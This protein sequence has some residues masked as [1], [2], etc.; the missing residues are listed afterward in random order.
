[1]TVSQPEYPTPSSIQRRL[2]LTTGLV[3]I[4]FLGLVGLVLDQA[5]RSSTIRGAEEQLKLLT[6]SLMGAAE[7]EGGTLVF[8]KDLF[9]P[10]LNQPASGLYAVVMDD[11]GTLL[12]QSPS[13]Q[14]MPP[15]SALALV[16]QLTSAN[17]LAA[18]EAAGVFYFA[19]IDEPQPLFGLS[20]T[21]TWEGLE[22]DVVTFHSLTAQAPFL[23]TINAFRQNVWVGFGLLTIVISIS[24]AAAL[25]WGLRPLRLMQQEVR[26]LEAGRRGRLTQEQPKE[27]VGLVDSLQRY[28][29]HEHRL[30]QRH[31]Q[32]LDNLA[33]SLKTPLAILRNALS[34][35][36]DA[37]AAKGPALR[38]QVDLMDGIITHQLRRLSTGTASAPIGQRTQIAPL[39]TRL[40]NAL[41][42][43][44]PDRVFET[45][46]DDQAG[47]R[48]HADDLYEIFGNIL[49]NACK[50]G[51]QKV[52]IQLSRSGDAESERRVVV[53]LEDDGPGIP[54]EAV[55]LVA[56][57]GQRLDT[58]LPG[59]GI[60]LAVAIELL[61]GS[62]GELGVGR[63]VL[64]GARLI[65]TLPD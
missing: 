11:L 34:A 19:Q 48:M 6:Y 21:V 53:C 35:S 59:Q 28:I 23:E 32:A 57:R 24:Q 10:R 4:F 58:Q 56:I 8:A 29:E 3:L 52:Q 43:A 40:V 9:Q 51:R 41:Q 13:L 26:E 54:E 47:S 49:D 31:R 63:S 44:Y 38:D 18:T 2:S 37:P 61:A 25:G 36:E 16:V 30:R 55:N 7:E 27:L 5:F 45:N 33:H 62:G 64:G 65:V 50:Y 12:W 42:V 20:Y 17:K 1:M 14:A 60:G 39:L 46:L 22:A 15:E